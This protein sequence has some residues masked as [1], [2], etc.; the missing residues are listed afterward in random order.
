LIRQ[1]PCQTSPLARSERFRCRIGNPGRPPG[2]PFAWPLTAHRLHW[3]FDVD[4]EWFRRSG[5]FRHDHQVSTRS[6]DD[7]DQ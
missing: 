4:P 5:V 2:K 6:F 3:M 7:G 1:P